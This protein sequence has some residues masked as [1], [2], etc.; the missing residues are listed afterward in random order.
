MKQKLSFHLILF[1]ML[2]ADVSLVQAQLPAELQTPEL[3]SINRMPMRNNAFAYENMELA[4]Q[5][6]REISAN[7]FSLNGS[8]KFN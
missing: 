2:V 3:V 8:W 5:R 1:I 7:F 4:R 6:N